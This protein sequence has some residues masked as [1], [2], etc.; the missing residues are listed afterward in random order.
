M[1]KESIQRGICMYGLCQ[2]SPVQA[3]LLP[4]IIAGIDCIC[5]A[6]Q[7]T[8]KTIA[9]IIGILQNIKRDRHCCQALVLAPGD[10][11]QEIANRFIDF[12]E[13]IKDNVYSCVGNSS[14]KNDIVKLKNPERPQVIVSSPKT[15]AYLLKKQT[16][17]LYDLE[18]LVLDKAD[19]LFNLSNSEI[20]IIMSFSPKHI[21]ICVISTEHPSYISEFT[22]TYMNDPAIICEKKK[23]RIRKSIKQYYISVKS[24]W[25]YDVLVDLYKS[26][27][28]SQT[29]IFCNER[30]TIEALAVKL[31]KDGLTVSAIHGDI[32]EDDRYRIMMEFRTSAS[33]VLVCTDIFAKRDYGICVGLVINYEMPVAKEA[34][35]HRIERLG[36]YNRTGLV[37]NFVTPGEAGVLSEI[38]EYYQTQM[39]ELPQDVTGI[40]S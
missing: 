34:Y 14:I 31:K 6:Q 21:Q 8:G 28:I 15:M 33:K 35:L 12:D 38:K 18:I 10:V 3:L 19:E 36:M 37:V 13:S 27:E 39:N 2:A 17:A 4:P 29:V 20:A 16:L 5:E 11:V 23:N 32:K 25:R 24:E 30:K 40:I 7:N 26:M 1:L 9:Y 22:A